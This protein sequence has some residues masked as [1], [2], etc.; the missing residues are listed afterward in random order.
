ME[1][2]RGYELS[3]MRDELVRL[4]RECEQKHAALQ[5]AQVM[6]AGAVSREQQGAAGC[7]AQGAE[8]REQGGGRREEGAGRR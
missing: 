8:S 2:R 3:V 1:K 6:S 5:K 4:E 7:R